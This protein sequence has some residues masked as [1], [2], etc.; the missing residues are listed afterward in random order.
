[1]SRS[2]F[3]ALVLASAAACS[4]QA[5][6]P[7]HAAQLNNAGVAA[8]SAG[9]LETAS[10]RFELALEYS[11]RFVDALTNQG[12]VELQ[13]GNLTRARQLIERARRLNPDVAQPHHA[14]G[15]LAERM[16]RP[17]EA[18]D[19]YRD[20]LRIDPGFSPSRANLGRLLFAQGH[21][22]HARE[23]YELLVEVAPDDPRGYSGL[24]QCL[25][26]LGR[27][28]EAM[29]V[30]ARGLDRF[31]DDPEL[32]IA[33]ARTMLETARPESARAR[34]E[35]LTHDTNDLAVAALGWTAVA[36]L[37]MGH[38]VQ[39]RLAAKR[40]LELD[41]GDALAAY[42]Y[43][44]AL[45]GHDDAAARAWRRRTL[46]LAPASPALRRALGARTS[47]SG[48]RQGRRNGL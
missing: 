11:P 25:I 16:Q 34:L 2:S 8:L 36:E 18:L 22:E 7:L 46:E 1:M 15:V 9:D 45:S 26:A 28:A 20:A 41:P 10:A 29:V 17:D 19:H 4:S 3:A 32:V 47:T 13:R 23:Q 44:V 14:L 31:P 5:P 40:A 6:L 24:A 27:L 12:L 30:V 37:S 48:R 43:S 42:A 39:G 35:P 38:A 33:D 21:R